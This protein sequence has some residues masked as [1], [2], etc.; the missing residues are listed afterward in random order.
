MLI[1]SETGTTGTA[2]TSLGS[3]LK[4]LRREGVVTDVP[5]ALNSEFGVTIR[6]VGLGCVRK[7]DFGG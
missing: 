5:A 1:T 4:P 2:K 7:D 3:Q 6:S